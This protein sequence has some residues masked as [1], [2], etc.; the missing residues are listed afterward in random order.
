MVVGVALLGAVGFAYRKMR[1]RRQQRQ[2]AWEED[3]GPMT[4]PRDSTYGMYDN[5]DPF[6]STLDQ[7]HRTPDQPMYGEYHQPQQNYQ[8]TY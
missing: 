4:Q 7:Y 2:H 8:H 6:K 3:F 1:S 5:S